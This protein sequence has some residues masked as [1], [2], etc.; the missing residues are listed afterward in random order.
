MNIGDI[1]TWI[2]VRSYKE[3]V[4]VITEKGLPDLISF[5]HDLAGEHYPLSEK[6]ESIDY[7]KYKEKTGYHCA[8]WL[9]EY[10]KT[11]NK[12]LPKW[13]VHSLNPVGRVNIVQLLTRFEGVSVSYLSE[14]E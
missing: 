9:V 1:R 2:V 13:Q 11:N 5:D 7:G 12:P 10:C 3:F 4:K 8:L 6:I 14:E